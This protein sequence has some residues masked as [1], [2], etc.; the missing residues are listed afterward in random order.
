MKKAPLIIVLSALSGFFM[1]APSAS[2]QV[3]DG[4]EPSEEALIEQGL[5]LRRERRDAEALALFERAYERN[6]SPRALAQV[7]LAQQA[8][9]R[10]LEAERT[11][12]EALAAEDDPW[13]ASRSELLR[14]ALESIREHLASLVVESNVTPS[15]LFLDGVRVGELPL[16]PLRVVAG[17]VRV[18]VRTEHHGAVKRSIEVKG[19]ATVVESIHFVSRPARTRLP[20]VPARAPKRPAPVGRAD[21]GVAPRESAFRRDLAFGL[22]GAAGAS[23][24][25]ALIAQFVRARHVARYN[26]DARCLYGELSRDE[27]CGGDRGAAETAQTYANIGYVGAVAFGAAAVLLLALPDERTRVLA[28][29]SPDSVRVACILR[30]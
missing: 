23:L 16:P 19:G 18:E 6:R 30:L 24:G 12:M 29:A 4:T 10:W 3:R 8:L 26:D 13:I 7:A 5:E 9:G 14:S 21:A 17:T 27:R 15:T 2:A 1:G 22:L 11:L 25:G 28:E 20:P